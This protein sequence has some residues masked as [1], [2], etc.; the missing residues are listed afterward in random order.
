[1]GDIT[2]TFAFCWLLVSVRQINYQ[3]PRLLYQALELRFL[4]AGQQNTNQE[5]NPKP[6]R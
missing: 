6:Y 3:I 5:R 1:M 2:Y 4:G